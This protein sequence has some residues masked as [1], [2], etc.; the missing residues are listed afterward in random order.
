MIYP[1]NMVIF[2]SYVSLPEA[3]CHW[4]LTIGCQGANHHGGG[5]ALQALLGELSRLGP[6]GRC[7][8]GNLQG[9]FPGTF[10][11]FSHLGNHVMVPQFVNAKLGNLNPMILGMLEHLLVQR[12]TSN[13]QCS[14]IAGS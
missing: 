10:D 3:N 8:K 4:F 13:N 11:G 1:L 2:Y 14:K 5:W 6:M 12:R 7:Y 9:R